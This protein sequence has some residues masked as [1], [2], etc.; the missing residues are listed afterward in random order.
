MFRVRLRKHRLLEG[1]ERS[2]LDDVGG[3]GAA[4][5][6]ED[7]RGQPP[8]EREHRAGDRHRDEQDAVR[9]APAEAVGVPA[10][11]DRGE[12]RP[13][14]QCEQDQADLRA[15]EPAFG[16]R[17]ADEHRAEPV[18][19]RACSLGPDDAAGVGAQTRSCA[20][21]TSALHQA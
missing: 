21:P 10:D 17:D 8:G 2:R 9:P 16:Q 14:K 11:G 20:I 5:R 13:C 1:S 4:E 12:R 18:R 3:H 19:G 6:G 7:Q 15:R